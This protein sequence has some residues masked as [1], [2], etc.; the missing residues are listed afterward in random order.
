LDIKSSSAGVK[1]ELAERDAILQQRAKT[2]EDLEWKVKKTEHR[3]SQI[4]RELEEHTTKADSEKQ[5]AL[6]REKTLEEQLLAQTRQ[7]ESASAGVN[8]LQEQLRKLEV[9]NQVLQQTAGVKQQEHVTAVSSEQLNVLRE[10]IAFLTQ[11]NQRLRSFHDKQRLIRDLPPLAVAT[12]ASSIL[13]ASMEARRAMVSTLS[14]NL[15]QGKSVESLVSAS[16]TPTSSA[17]TVSQALT[18]VVST[19]ALPRAVDL[20]DATTSPMDQLKTINLQY[21]K[22]H[23]AATQI[24]SEASQVLVSGQFI[25]RES[26]AKQL[27]DATASLKTGNTLGGAPVGRV[28]LPAATSGAKVSVSKAELE[29]L[30]SSLIS[31][32]PIH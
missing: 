19:V 31:I 18:A 7:T 20:S 26:L 13:T 2:I 32:N 3:V 12:P 9:E 24:Q 29:S 10:A 21:R 23:R 6:S 30:H 15:A 14:D 5:K 4:E 8:E 16:P 22:L 27:K 28:S 1:K 11:E 25:S 17:R